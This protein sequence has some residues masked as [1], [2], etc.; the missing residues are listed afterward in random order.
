[1][2]NFSLITQHFRGATRTQ[3]RTVDTTPK[4]LL[5][6]EL[7]HVVLARADTVTVT[8]QAPPWPLDGTKTLV[9]KANYT[10]INAGL[11][12]SGLS[13]EFFSFESGPPHCNF[14][15]R[16]EYL[17]TPLPSGIITTTDPAKETYTTTA[18]TNLS[19]SG[20]KCS[21][22][23]PAPIP[24][25]KCINIIEALGPLYTYKGVYPCP[26]S[27]GLQRCDMWINKGRLSS[28]QR[29]T[30]T[31]TQTY[32]FIINTNVAVQYRVNSTSAAGSSVSIL[33]FFGWSVNTPVPKSVW[34]VPVDWQPYTKP[35]SSS[36]LPTFDAYH[37]SAFSSALQM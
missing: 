27:A 19:Y 34:D 20:P 29:H 31:M 21:I 6:P 24:D 15:H 33:E 37:A 26:G 23:G 2:R 16:I 14:R 3:W 25:D 35:T 17:A 18:F 32:Y 30:M 1:M 8:A 13:N 22:A 10:F 12:T 4:A 28:Q 5:E 11:T 36:S 7:R 9:A